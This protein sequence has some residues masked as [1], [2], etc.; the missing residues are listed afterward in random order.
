MKVSAKTEYACLAMLRLAASTDHDEPVR[1]R[2]LADA[3]GIPQRFLVQIL[4]QLKAA[5]L[6]ASTRGA[7]GGYQLV[8]SADA[9]SLA[10]V[11]DVF[12]GAEQESPPSN[13][14]SSAGVHA[15]RGVWSEADLAQRE[16]LSS[17]TLAQ[18]L[19]RARGRTEDMYY[20]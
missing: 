12:E 16:V 8:G 18:L 15:L 7:A 3:H 17:I 6:V 11:V 14:Q 5:G 20:I 4:L 13:L 2:D 19:E 9:I 10:D 1:I